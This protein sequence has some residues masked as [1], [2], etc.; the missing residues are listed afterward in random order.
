MSI[1][2]P[3]DQLHTPFLRTRSASEEVAAL[4][5]SEAY[6]RGITGIMVGGFIYA[7]VFCVLS[8]TTAGSLAAL[9]FSPIIVPAVTLW[10][11]VFCGGTYLG[12]GKLAHQIGIGK[13]FSVPANI[14]AFCAA[15]IAGFV[16]ALP[17]V[18]A[19]II[20]DNPDQMPT[21]GFIVPLLFLVQ[22]AT[23]IAVHRAIQAFHRRPGADVEADAAIET[24]QGAVRSPPIAFDA[25]E[26]AYIPADQDKL[27]FRLSH[28]MILPILVGVVSFLCVNVKWFGDTMKLYAT[29]QAFAAVP[30]LV[31][32]GLSI[33]IGRQRDK[34][35]MRSRR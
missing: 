8:C 22:T 26:E 6:W 21:V 1:E 5:K 27:R 34:K 7:L 13:N 10:V 11:I 15:G 30:G 12:L 9:L 35:R 17:L 19:W 4:T 25:D 23:F 16:A 3:A 33:F 18:L 28:L 14:V 24:D 29:S 2:S 31:I 32:V 20:S